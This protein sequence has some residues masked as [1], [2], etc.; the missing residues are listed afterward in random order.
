MKKTIFAVCL[1][2]VGS[3]MSAANAAEVMSAALDK[4]GKN[5]LVQVNYGGGCAEHR[6]S[7]SA[8]PCYRDA[9]QTLV[10]PVELIHQTTDGCEAYIEQTL[11]FSLKKFGFDR[12]EYVGALIMVFGDRPHGSA[13]PSSAGVRMQK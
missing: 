1:M 13:E 2:V 12:A 4:T 6:F 5:I 3:V 11:S 8:K 7:W 9:H 10:C